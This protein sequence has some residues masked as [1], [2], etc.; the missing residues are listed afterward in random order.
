MSKPEEKPQNQSRIKSFLSKG[1]VVVVALVVIV[2]FQYLNTGKIMG[3]FSFLHGHSSSLIEEIGQLKE[4]QKLIANSLNEIRTF[5]RMPSGPQ[6]TF[7]SD[8]RST[9]DKED[10]NANELQIAFFHYI[11]SLARERATEENLSFHKIL[12]KDLVKSDEVSVFLKNEELTF[13]E[14]IENEHGVFLSITSDE[15]GVLATYSYE[16]NSDT[17]FIETQKQKSKISVENFPEFEENA[18]SFLKNQKKSLVK[19]LEEIEKRKT[20]V[21]KVLSLP[22][23]ISLMEEKGVTVSSDYVFSNKSGET[24]GSIIFNTESGRISLND[25]KNPDLSLEITDAQVSLPPFLKKLDARTQ[26]ETKIDKTLNDIQQTIDDSGFRTLLS[27]SNLKISKSPREDNFRYYYDIFSK[28]DEHLSSIVIEK[29]TGIVNIVSPE[30]TNSQNIFFF[31]PESKKKTLN[32]PDEI[33]FYSDNPN[34]TPG[35]LNILVAG[36]HGGLLDAMI[37]VHINETRKDIRLVSIPRDLFYN[38][39]KINAFAVLY[40][41]EEL[42]R[43]IGEITGYRPDK[44]ISID[45]YAFIDV[46]DII[47]GVEITLEKAVIDPFYRTVD[48]GKVGTL[49]YPPG[50]YHF[51]GVEALR[52][53]RSRYTSSDFARAERQHLILQAIK[54]KAKNFGFSN[55]DVIYQIIRSVLSKTTTNI[56]FEDAIVWFFRYQNYEIKSGGVLSSGNVLYVPPYITTENCQK[57]IEEAEL[58]DE[59]RPDCENQNNAYTLLPRDDNW[60][61]IKWFFKQHFE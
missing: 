60:N 57:M 39:R 9:P 21:D 53:A 37:L 45:M 46:I 24:L 15:Y 30:G 25:Y 5:L 7:G 29:T 58:S 40:G 32:L 18:L 35:T 44:Y 50:D 52:L 43:V 10:L 49:H 11:D 59:P 19:F 2:L 54:D 33:P 56:S 3:S 8:T 34:N 17:F 48:N 16:I 41:I 23:V 20:E 13:T 51:S 55:A 38:G 28:S 6:L 27:I 12:L 26:L 1:N 36:T 22:E 14:I 47:G 42:S 61:I 4:N 31:D